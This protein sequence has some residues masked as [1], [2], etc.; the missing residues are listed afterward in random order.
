MTIGILALQ[1]DVREHAAAFADLGETVREVR[2]PV[3]LEGLAGLVVPG[4]E[5]T[6]LSLLL[7]SAG[8]TDPLTEAL[9]GG[10]PV[11]GTCAGMILLATTV[12]DGRPDQLSFGAIELRQ[13]NS[14]AIVT[15]IDGVAARISG[16]SYSPD[17]QYL[18]APVAT[19]R[20]ACGA[21]PTVTT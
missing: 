17:G 3:D 8:L 20:C 5:S 4:G 15:T 12:L 1:G 10:L 19:A 2:R 16:L 18:A 11:F 13:V 6:T 21:P 14:G 7:G 9:G